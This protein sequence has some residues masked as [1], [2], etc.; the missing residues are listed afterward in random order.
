MALAISRSMS[1]ADRAIRVTTGNFQM[2]LLAL[3]VRA[4]LVSLLIPVPVI[5][6]MFLGAWLAP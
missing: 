6:S 1:P 4:F 5:G 3:V 2:L